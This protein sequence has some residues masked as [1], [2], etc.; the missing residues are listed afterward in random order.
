MPFYLSFYVCGP[1]LFS[2]YR[3]EFLFDEPGLQRTHALETLLL[4]FHLLF[5]FVSDSNLLT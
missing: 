1:C 5:V 2:I 4:F 3:K